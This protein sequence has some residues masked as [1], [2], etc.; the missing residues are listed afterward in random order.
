[1]STPLV[2]YHSNCQD[3]FTAA[4]AIWKVHPDWEFYPAKQ[5]SGFKVPYP[6]RRI[7]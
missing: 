2:I 1:M 6:F 4:W 7:A 5:A 3:G